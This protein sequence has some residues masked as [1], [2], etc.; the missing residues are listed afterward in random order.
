LRKR[1]DEFLHSLHLFHDFIYAILQEGVEHLAAMKF[2]ASALGVRL[3]DLSVSGIKDKRG[4]THQVIAPQKSNKPF[5]E[6]SYN[7]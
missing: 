1:G 7:H 5:A 2:V 4:Q 6:L 3:Q